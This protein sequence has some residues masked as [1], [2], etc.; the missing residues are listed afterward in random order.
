MRVLRD[1]AELLH[2]RMEPNTSTLER[3]FQLAR[4]GRHTS[5]DAIRKQLQK[6]GYTTSQLFGRTL[7]KQLRELIDAAVAERTEDPS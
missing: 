2:S 7:H 3:A 1:G 6:E 5:V 4:T